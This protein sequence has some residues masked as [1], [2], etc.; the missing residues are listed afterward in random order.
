MDYVLIYIKEIILKELTQNSS[1]MDNF[2]DDDMNKIRN[3]RYDTRRKVL[4]VVSKNYIDT[5]LYVV[6]D[7][8]LKCILYICLEMK[9]MFHWLFVC[10]PIKYL[11]FI[12]MWIY[13]E[14]KKYIEII[15]SI[16]KKKVQYS[17]IQNI[18]IF[19]F[20]IKNIYLGEN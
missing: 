13:I 17:S 10:Y 8:G 4:P 12:N 9:V 2:T 20:T 16:K 11:K 1:V 15:F 6:L 5:H 14:H 18:F 7:F 3:V 19:L